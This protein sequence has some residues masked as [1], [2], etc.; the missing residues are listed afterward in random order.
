MCGI[1]ISHFK[2]FLLE[3]RALW[4]AIVTSNI[5]VNNNAPN[6]LYLSLAYV[7]AAV[8]AVAKRGRRK[9]P[10]LYLIESGHSAFLRLQSVS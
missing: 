1:F 6:D 8:L 7:G 5:G 9:G 2:L 4:N 10:E 3:P